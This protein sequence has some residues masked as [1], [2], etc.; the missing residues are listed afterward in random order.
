MLKNVFSSMH[1]GTMEVANRLVVP[2]M[3]MN[4]CNSDGTATEKFIA[5][6]EAKAKGGWELII[7]EDYAVDPCGKGFPC[8]PGLWDN[9]QIE[10]HSELTER[11]HKYGS[12]IVAQIY[13]AGRQTNHFITGMQPVAP[14]PIPCP[15][16]QEIPHE[17]TISEIHDIVNKYGDCALRAKEAGFDGVEVHGAHGYLVAQF[18]SPYSNKRTDEYGGSLLNRMRFP[19]EIISNIR[20]KAGNV[21][22]IIF[23]ISGDEFV[24]G[25]R[26]IEDTKAISVLLEQ[27]GVNAIHVSAG[28]YAS[29]QTIIPPAAVRHGWITD[30]AADVKKVVSIPVITVGRIN[31]PIM[32]ETIIAS[33]KAD[34]VAMGRASL[35]D[36][37]LP[38]KAAAGRFDDINYCIGCL[39][40]CI[41]SL[42]KGNPGGCL[43]NPVTGRESELIIEPAEQKKKVFVA[44]GGPAGMEAAMVAAQRGHE[45]HLY[46]KSDRVGG[47]YAIGAIPPNK[48][49]IDMFIVWQYN[50]LKKHGVNIH[51]NTELTADIVEQETPD[52]VIVATGGEPLIPNIPGKDRPNVV[53]AND[54]LLGKVNVGHR[55]IVIGGGMVGSETADHLANHGKEVMIVE[56]LPVI[57]KDEE[58]A[59]RYFLMKDL[60]QNDVKI[61][62]NAPVKEILDDGIISEI[63]GT[64]TKIGPADTIVLAIGARSVNTLTRQLEGKVPQV[65]AIGDAVKV[66]KALEAVE[67][68]YRAGL[69]V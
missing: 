24:P 45:V 31:D 27:A 12:K 41:G 54:V 55:V 18:M 19:L 14:S 57:A 56:M 69:A 11:V 22:P 63:D 21:F 1:I 8:I 50:Q 58:A 34:F 48:G 5:Y 61:Y 51:F 67:A 17:L 3:V 26:T 44:G 35:A 28:V 39:Q 65:I 10:S 30:F 52:A 36:P 53:N 20:A 33:G 16:N 23:R 46:E 42:N 62:V 68:G 37:E 60:K 9:A 38:N 29:M 7:T 43:V 32:A 13:H 6:H 59:V 15:A 25:G 4:F 2:A 49:E 47:Q 40:G 64:E 66:C